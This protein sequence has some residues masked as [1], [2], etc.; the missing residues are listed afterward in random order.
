MW[1]FNSFVVCVVFIVIFSGGGVE[2]SLFLMLIGQP[3]RLVGKGE[4]GGGGTC[5]DM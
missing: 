2:F 3:T 1:N 4:G 5:M